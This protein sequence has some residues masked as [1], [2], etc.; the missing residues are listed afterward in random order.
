MQQSVA[1]EE[2]ADVETAP[3]ERRHGLLNVLLAGLVRCG[4]FPDGR[5]RLREKAEFQ[6]NSAG[7]I[8]PW[9]KPA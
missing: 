3:V 1:S 6:V 2:M 4:T 7:S 8:P 5:K 9:L